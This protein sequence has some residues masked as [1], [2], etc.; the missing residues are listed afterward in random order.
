MKRVSRKQFLLSLLALAVPVKVTVGNIIMT[1][2]GPLAINRLGR[3]LIH[4]HILVDFIGADKIN[5]ARWDKDEVVKKVLPY[6]MEA[7]RHHVDA[8]FDCT[9]AF[10]G[11]DVGLLQRVSKETGLHVITNT[12]YYGAVK[13]KYL[14][15]WAFTESA[16]Q[17]AERWI[18]E[19]E[20]GIEG[21]AIK[22]GFIKIGVDSDAPLSEVHRKLVKAAAI[23]HL[24]TGLTIFSHTG[25]AKA[26]Y[27]QLD[28]LSDSGV[29]ASAF[30]WVHA[31]VEKDKS[32]FIT[33]G[34]Q[35][36]WVSLDGMGWG[37]ADDY[38]DS[39][40]RMKAARLLN[41]VLISH[42]AGWYKPGEPQGD[43]KGYTKIFTELIPK[44]KKQGFSR[45]DIDQLLVTNPAEAMSV[46]VRKK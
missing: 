3:A 31:Q 1:V 37:K 27:E 29:D 44:L 41:R 39:L 34:R 13:N 36:C 7:R 46:Q 23:T 45:R 24:K 26:A 15:P 22:P 20:S 28:I 42:D 11:R 43:F 9:P 6:L 5:Y 25:L 16:E 14:P 2:N 38:V 30:V 4:E 12:G 35:R 10:L 32:H 19:Y 33:A 8:F 17:L 18:Q 21:T 40:G